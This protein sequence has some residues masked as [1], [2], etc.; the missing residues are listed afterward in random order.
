MSVAERT[1]LLRAERGGGIWLEGQT[2]MW[3]TSVKK[4]TREAGI[5]WL[6]RRFYQPAV[7]TEGVITAKNA[8]RSNSCW[9]IFETDVWSI[10][11]MN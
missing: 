9:V 4:V 2:R 7:R 5:G 8:H 3:T 1:L 11:S 10:V 6:V